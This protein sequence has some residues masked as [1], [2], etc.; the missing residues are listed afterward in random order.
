MGITIGFLP[1][2][3]DYY[4]KMKTGVLISQ[5]SKGVDNAD[6]EKEW[7]EALEYNK[8]ALQTIVSTDID[9]KKSYSERYTEMLNI[10]KMM[11]Y[12]TIPG[13]DT[14]LPIYHGTSTQSLEK[15]VGHLPDSSLPVGGKGTHCVIAGH[16]GIEVSRMFN[17]L[18]KMKI[19]DLFYLTVCG[20][21]LCY[22]VDNIAV[23]LPEDTKLLERVA[24]KDYCTLVT[25]TPYGVN[26]HRLLVRG[27]RVDN[28]TN[29][30]SQSVLK[31]DNTVVMYYILSILAV[32]IIFIVLTIVFNKKGKRHE[33]KTYSN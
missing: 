31:P 26:T 24:D 23:V 29:T 17:D 22:K 16:T 7:N 10:N 19:G 9:N 20:K 13:I 4:Y 30:V 5:S 21:E 28:D 33:D 11:G 8:E 27:V 15:G 2:L 1:E 12:V 25:C 14:Q 18:N 32:I 3:H 6:L